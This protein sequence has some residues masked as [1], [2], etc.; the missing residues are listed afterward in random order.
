[1]LYEVI[2]SDGRSQIETMEILSYIHHRIL[3]RG[4][5][6]VLEEMQRV[7]A[8]PPAIKYCFIVMGSG[9]RKEMLL[10]PDQD[11]GFIFENYPDDKAAEVEA[12]FAPFSEKL[13]KAY[14]K[15]GYPLCKGG[16]MA[17]NPFWRGRLKDWQVKVANWVNAPEP[18]R[19]RYSTI[20]FDFMPLVG[21]PSLGQE[22]RGISYNFV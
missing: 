4:F 19:V 11:N 14:A 6:I 8:T 15:I 12:F 2:T 13:V 22:L 21:E 20:F 3:R 10:D 18:Q 16:V 1:M 7:G 5:E 17:S 9:G